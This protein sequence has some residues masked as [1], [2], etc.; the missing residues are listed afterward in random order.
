[1]ASMATVE[2]G[3]V[4]AEQGH[5]LRT[6][7]SPFIQ[8]GFLQSCALSPLLDWC[9]VRRMDGGL[10]RGNSASP[11]TMRAAATKHMLHTN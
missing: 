1:M 5:I 8:K 3:A 2:T 6:Q 4:K 10:P 11:R 7:A 9:P